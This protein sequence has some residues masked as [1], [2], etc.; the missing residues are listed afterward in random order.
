MKVSAVVAERQT[1]K[2]ESTGAALRLQEVELSDEL[3]DKEVLVRVVAC[4][5]CRADLDCVDGKSPFPLPA[6][7]GHE[8]TGVVERVG[9]RVQAVKPG[10]HVIMAF[11]NDG[12]CPACLRGKPRQ[13]VKG[14]Q[15]MWSGK[16]SDGSGS[17]WSRDGEEL[18]G[19]QFQQ[20]AFATRAIATEMNCVVVPDDVPLDTFVLGCGVMTGAGGVLNV[21]KPE[22]GSSIVVLGVGGVGSAAV[23]AAK[24]TGCVPIIAIDPRPNR[25]ALAMEIGATHALDPKASDLS[26]QVNAITG[27]GADYLISCSPDNEAISHVL[28]LVKIGGKCGMIGDPGAGIEARFVVSEL[29]GGSK[30]IIGINGG[31]AVAQTFLPLLIAAHARGEFPLEKV[32]RRYRL[33]DIAQAFADVE[34]G[35][36]IKPVILI[37][38]VSDCSDQFRT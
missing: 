37:G 25:R 3:L 10:D 12:T 34:S 16:R 31:E 35:E 11:P 33:A 19:H 8:G 29:L 30:S 32:Q 21:L 2:G 26:E 36:T 7:L 22:P 9:A 27:A 24:L 15:L 38:D 1:E 28:D 4:G 18:A 5:V 14:K 17:A 13:C 20:S 23:M 6:V